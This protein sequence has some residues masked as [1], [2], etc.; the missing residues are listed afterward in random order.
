M[1][2][3]GALDT[4]E[5]DTTPSKKRART[6]DEEDRDVKR[7]RVSE[8]AMGGENTIDGRA[9]QSKKDKRKRKK[10]KRRAAV[11]QNVAHVPESGPTVT[12]TLS[13]LTSD[14]AAPDPAPSAIAS[15]DATRVVSPEFV[16]GSSSG[17]GSSSTSQT[18]RAVVA[19]PNADVAQLT[20]SLSS[21]TEVRCVNELECAF[22]TYYPNF[23]VP[24]HP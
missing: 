19:L 24:A 16:Q 17:P 11:I 10:K 6:L 21:K 22:S 7:A 1:P 20:Q 14:N 2:S 18:A 3:I 12:A 5:T 15:S 4:H 8:D 9:T 23:T 13:S